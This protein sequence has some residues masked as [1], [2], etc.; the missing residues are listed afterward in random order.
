M[1]D[2][3]FPR[4]ETSSLEGRALSIRFR[5]RLFHSLY[6]TVK[7]SQAIIKDAIT[8]DFGCSEH[9][10]TLEYALAVSELRL[11]Y[12]SLDLKADVKRAH[13]LEDLEGSTGVG[14]VYV[15]PSKQ[16]L[17]YSVVSALAAA[18]AA[19]N[20]VILEVRPAELNVLKPPNRSNT[21]AN[22]ALASFNSNAI[23]W[24]ASQAS[25]ISIG[26]GRVCNQ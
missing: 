9:E 15:I 26:L 19:G 18:L 7:A 12:D 20:C 1:S 13:S 8:A 11:H 14:I 3:T 5:E 16:N 17:F 25:T 23:V 4:I 10:A 22:R 21:A 6:S 24:I 2:D